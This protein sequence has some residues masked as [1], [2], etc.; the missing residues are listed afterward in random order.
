MPTANTSKIAPPSATTEFAVEGMSCASCVGRVERLFAAH[1][2]VTQASV[3]LAT[4]RASVQGEFDAQLLARMVTEGGYAT[5][6]IVDSQQISEQQIQKKQQEFRILKRDFFQALLLTLPVFIVEMTMHLSPSAAKAIDQWLPQQPRWWIEC[7]LTSLV[8]LFPGRR[9]YRLGLPALWQGAPDMNALVAIGTLAA[10]GYSLVATFLPA[11]LPT[12]SVHVYYEAAATIVVLVLL[13]RL[14]ESRAKGQTSEALQRLAKLQPFLS[15]VWRDEQWIELATDQLQR[16]DVVDVR[17]GE[18]IATDGQL[19]AGQSYI[20]ESMITGEAQPVAKQVGD[21]LTGGTLNQQGSLQ[22]KVTATG[23]QTLLAQII[24]LVQSAQATKLPI[25]TQVDK[26]TRWFVPGVLLAALLT[27]IAW[28]VWGP[29]PA[30]SLAIV[31]TVAVLIIACPCA[32]G[33]A[34][35]TSIM[36]A[37]GRGAELGILFRQGS[38]LELLRSTRVV[39]F[40]KTGTLTQGA[41]M[42]TD[43][44][45]VKGF[46][47]Q[48]VLQQLASVEQHSEHPIAQALVKAAQQ[49]GLTL[50]KVEQFN[51]LSGLGV[52]GQVEGQHLVIGADRYLQQLGIAVDVFTKQAEQLAKQGKSPCY[53]AVN[54]QLAAIFAVADPIKP[55]THQAIQQLTGQGLVVAMVTGDHRLTAQAVAEQLGISQVIAEVA[56]SGKVAAITQLKQTYGQVAFV[57]DGINDAPALASADVGIALGTGTDIAIES[58]QVVLMSGELSGVVNGIALSQAAM[59]NIQQNLFWAFIYNLALIPVA[60]GAL[61]ASFG[62]LMSP[63]LAA[64]AMALSSVFVVSNALRLRRLRLPG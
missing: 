3:N 46:S 7:I 8:L 27:F 57:G 64:G 54:Q 22:F 60:A 37:T 62:I 40:D 53:V 52:V 21:K 1:P 39:V 23:D 43:L 36:V 6:V 49:Q 11:Y 15:R 16:D 41:P 5:T 25:Q 55:S 4:E 31:N 45:V 28:L 10:W 33:L 12:G 30:L 56:P 61:Y 17:P 9:F 18:R 58:A 26:I 51:A 14:L 50:G 59:T 63:M 38:A 13:G 35:P 24:R 32:M 47:S 42:L 2:G 19:I 34:T 20:D 29:A 44:H 48:S